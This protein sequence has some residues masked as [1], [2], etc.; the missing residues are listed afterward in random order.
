MK[1]LLDPVPLAGRVVTADDVAEAAL[2]L[3]QGNKGVSGVIVTVDGGY[4][5]V[6]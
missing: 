6:T 4:A 1:P 5:A 2:S 3:I